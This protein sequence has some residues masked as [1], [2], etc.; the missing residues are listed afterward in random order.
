[1]RKIGRIIRKSIK[2]LIVALILC[3]VVGIILSVL[4]RFL[5]VKIEAVYYVLAVML[6]APVIAIPM[7][8]VKGYNLF[9]IKKKEIYNPIMGTKRKKV[10]VKS[11]KH[12]KSSH[13]HEKEY[14]RRKAS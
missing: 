3:S 5:D 2:T 6:S 10:T 12:K 11:K 8:F 1:M 9:T 13:N 4:N 7:Y 14:Q